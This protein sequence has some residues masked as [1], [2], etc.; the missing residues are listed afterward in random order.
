MNSVEVER[1]TVCK[2]KNRKVLNT[3]VKTNIGGYS[4]HLLQCNHYI[5]GDPDCEKCRKDV[6]G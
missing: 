2:K 3:V 4:F 1:V 5:T 6:F